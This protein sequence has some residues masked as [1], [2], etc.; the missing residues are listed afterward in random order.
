M[1]LPK[2]RLQLH[3]RSFHNDRNNCL[4]VPGNRN[5][6][7]HPKFCH[8]ENEK[9]F[10]L[11]YLDKKKRGREKHK[12]ERNNELIGNVPRSNTSFHNY[13]EIIIEWFHRTT[14]LSVINHD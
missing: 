6:I 13:I 4:M 14:R 9:L 11:H 7:H 5:A 2:T 8:D 1:R 3:R 10:C 12:E